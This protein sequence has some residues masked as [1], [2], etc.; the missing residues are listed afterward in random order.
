MRSSF[1]ENNND[2]NELFIYFKKNL[3]KINGSELISE[4]QLKLDLPKD[5]PL[6]MKWFK[7][8]KCGDEVTFEEHGVAIMVICGNGFKEKLKTLI[9]KYKNSK[10]VK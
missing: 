7:D 10:K 6:P 4:E 9:T 1:G 5:I 8:R 3:G 2:P